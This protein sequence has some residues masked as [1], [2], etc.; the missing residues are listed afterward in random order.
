[1]IRKV[2][3]FTQGYYLRFNENGFI[4]YLPV[5]REG[6]SWSETIVS[7]ERIEAYYEY[8]AQIG[9]TKNLGPRPQNLSS[10]GQKQNWKFCDYCPLK[11]TCD[12][13]ESDFDTWLEAAKGIVPKA[14]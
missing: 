3:P 7:P 1:V 5:G 4:E 13:H 14:E 6:E 2:L 12:A 8:V 9:T 11:A 10:T